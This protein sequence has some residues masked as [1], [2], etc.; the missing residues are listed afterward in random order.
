MSEG[1][2]HPNPDGGFLYLET[3][4][5]C[6]AF[7]VVLIRPGTKDGRGFA[8]RQQPPVALEPEAAALATDADAQVGVDDAR[9][10]V[11]GASVRARCAEL[12]HALP[13]VA[14]R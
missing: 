4:L 12:F 2:R 6:D 8:P 7:L 3:R 9:D 5:P 14:A 1:D 13:P 10:D 11:G